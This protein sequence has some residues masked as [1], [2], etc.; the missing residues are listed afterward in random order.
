MLVARIIG[1]TTST[2]KH[3]TLA[4]WRLLVAQPTTA[5]GR[6]DGDPIVVLD[7]LGCGRG[8]LAMITSD[9]ASV[10]A[11]VGSKQCPARWAVIGILDR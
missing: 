3:P 5:D 7:N 2:V 10:R 9:G 8:D 1:N 4:G 6:D 11:M